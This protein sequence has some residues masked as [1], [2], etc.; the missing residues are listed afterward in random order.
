MYKKDSIDKM[1]DAYSMPHWDRE[2]MERSDLAKK[3]EYVRD[4]YNKVNVQES[5]AS[6]EMP[7]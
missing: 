1:V 5:Y 2:V 6:L 4:V 7:F 3:I